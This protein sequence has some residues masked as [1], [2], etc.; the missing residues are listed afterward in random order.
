[1]LFRFLGSRTSVREIRQAC[2]RPSLVGQGTVGAL[3]VPPRIPAHPSKRGIWEE[4]QL[5]SQRLI[6]A[7]ESGL[8]AC[9]EQLGDIVLR[10]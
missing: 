8:L 10:F 2:L 3:R 7:V 1:M 4:S 6:A 9:H 5:P